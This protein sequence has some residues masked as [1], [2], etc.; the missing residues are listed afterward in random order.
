MAIKIA[1]CVL[2][3]I[4]FTVN[5]S[6]FEDDEDDPTAKNAITTKIK[7]AKTAPPP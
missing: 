5:Q 3:V 4:V 1:R 7:I 2:T 6:F